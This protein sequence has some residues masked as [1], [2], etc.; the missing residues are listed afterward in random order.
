MNNLQMMTKINI[1][2]NLISGQVVHLATED[3]IKSLCAC[4]KNMLNI[5]GECPFIDHKTKF[6]SEDAFMLDSC[7]AKFKS[8][9]TIATRVYYE[10]ENIL[11]NTNGY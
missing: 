8:D 5:L 2:I 9:L 3:D 7:P 1:G 4:V 11:D 6:R 10:G